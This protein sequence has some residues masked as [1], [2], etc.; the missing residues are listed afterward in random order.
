MVENGRRSNFELLDEME[1]KKLKQCAKSP[2][3]WGSLFCRYAWVRS[4]SKAL[5][6]GKLKFPWVIAIGFLLMTLDDVFTDSVSW[7]SGVGAIVAVTGAVLY[8]RSALK[9]ARKKDD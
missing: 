1:K 3:G 9:Y 4:L 5:D 6:F 2:E 8:I 7:I